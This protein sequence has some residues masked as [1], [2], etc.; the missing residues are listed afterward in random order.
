MR[1]IELFVLMG[2]CTWAG[3]VELQA[4][5]PDAMIVTASFDFIGSIV[6]FVTN[7][8][9]VLYL[10]FRRRLQ[11][12]RV[13]FTFG[14]LLVLGASVNYLSFEQLTDRLAQI[15]TWWP[16]TSWQLNLTLLASTVKNVIAFGFG[17]IGAGIASSVVCRHS[18]EAPQSKGSTN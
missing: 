1:M 14:I 17:A 5:F 3:I 6:S 15:S 18:R 8:Y 10:F 16:G 12:D 13:K 2:L 9:F 7:T 4:Q 11:S